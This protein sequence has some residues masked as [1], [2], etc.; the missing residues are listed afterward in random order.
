MTKPPQHAGQKRQHEEETDSAMQLL[1]LDIKHLD[2][3][4]IKV[5]N[6]QKPTAQDLLWMS[7]QAIPVVKPR[8]AESRHLSGAGRKTTWWIGLMQGP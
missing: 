1:D 4:S 7:Q 3:S 6:Y 5:N 2:N 8:R